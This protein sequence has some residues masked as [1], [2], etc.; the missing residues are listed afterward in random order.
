MKVAID[1]GPLTGADAVRGIGFHTQLL[2]KHLRKI[3]DVDI[4]PVSFEATDLSRYDVLHYPSFHPH[5]LTLPSKKLRPSVLT[6]HDLIRL[7][8][9]KHYPPGI[10]GKIRFVLQ[11]ARLKNI[12]R[13][14]TIS[15]TSKKDIVRFLGIQAE[16][17]DVVYLAP[18]SMFKK[19]KSG[20]WEKGI[21][22]KYNL[23]DKFVLYVGDVNYNKNLLRLADACKRVGVAL[24]IVGKQA[25]S[26]DFEPGHIENRPFARFLKKY[27]GDKDILRPGFVP[28]EDLV[29]IYNLASLYAQPSLYE[30]FGLPVL[31]AMACQTPV[32][33]AK[34][35]ALVEIARDA[36][37]FVD[38]KDA[39]EIE[40]GLK[41]LLVDKRLRKDF[42]KKGS[43]KV[44]GYSWKK[45]AQKTAEVY[46]KVSDAQG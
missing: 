23:P 2:I 17:I 21:R 14:I 35:Q 31:E 20:N 26:T 37:Y 36:A 12:D 45:T 5:F 27:G 39:K 9:P 19:L 32:L 15:E 8:Y 24:V 41:K 28:D 25:A 42:I 4:D 43:K 30:G 11:K 1:K 10:A 13:V 38:P 22:D 18:R 16:K 40:K 3:K 46:R 29:K 34:T 44:K 33:S 6:T 7:V